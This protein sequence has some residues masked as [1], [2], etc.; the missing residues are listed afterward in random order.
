MVTRRGVAQ[1]GSSGKHEK[2]KVNIEHTVNAVTRGCWRVG[3]LD[4]TEEVGSLGS[5]ESCC[6]PYWKE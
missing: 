3:E 6:N 4:A 1:E 5:S 2:G